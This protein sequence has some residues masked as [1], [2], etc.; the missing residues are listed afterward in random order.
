MPW[1]TIGN[2]RGPRGHQGVPGDPLN[3]AGADFMVKNF[4]F[5]TGWDKRAPIIGG[6]GPIFVATDRNSKETWLGARGED[7]GPTDTALWHMQNRL[8]VHQHPDASVSWAVTDAA[9]RYTEMR[10]DNE[11]NVP[12]AVLQRWASRMGAATGSGLATGDRY[13]TSD[14]SL[15]PVFPDVKNITIWGSSSAERIG[16]ALSSALA[17]TGATFHNE[18]KG[19]ETS[20]HISARLGSVPAL[21][22]VA[23]GSIPAS[24]PVTVTASNMGNSA[25]M[26]P[27]VGALNGVKGQLTSTS[28]VFTFTRS[29]PGETT[30]VVAGTA[31][32]PTIG[33]ASRQHVTFL[34]MGKNNLS[35]SGSAPL[36]I[37]QTNKAFD[38]LSPMVKRVLVLGHFVDTAQSSGSTQ[39]TNVRTVNAAL[40][41]RYGDL[42]LDVDAYLSSPQLW[43]DTG[44]TPTSNDL[45]QQGNGIKPDSISHDSGHLNAAGYT[46]VSALIRKKLSALGWY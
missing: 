1:V 39:W 29:T 7:G 18:G 43:T 44:I 26:K 36:V 41:A 10:L 34:W 14:G 5:L 8:G 4:D 32:I 19:A 3:Q 37:E 13:I 35:G 23:G 27:F 31:F 24:G 17:S 9:W 25:E 22:T 6:K 46:A 45:V 12:D 40:A 42:F 20:Q 11:G 28:T 33:T 16:A 2:V 38:Y 21:L 15:S 30:S